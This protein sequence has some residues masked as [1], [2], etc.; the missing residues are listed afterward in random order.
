MKEISFDCLGLTI[1]LIADD[2]DLMPE[3]EQVAF[4]TTGRYENRGRLRFRVISLPRG[5]TVLFNDQIV[6][7][8]IDRQY[9]PY[10][11]SVFVHNHIASA[12]GDQGFIH[13]ACAVHRGRAF[14]IVGDKGA[15]KTTLSC[16]MLVQG[17]D[18]Q[19]DELV[20]PGREGVTPLPRKLLIKEG[21]PKL[22]T[23]LQGLLK[24]SISHHSPRY[25]WM[26]LVDPAVFNPVLTE[27]PLEVEAVF[28]LEADHK[29]PTSVAPLPGWQ[30]AARMTGQTFPAGAHRP[31]LLDRIAG[32]VRKCR[33]YSLTPGPPR[34][35]VEAITSALESRRSQRLGG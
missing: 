16:Q 9:L 17:M 32:L 12:L 18:V 22:V 35:A 15:G 25:G 28:C 20:I 8:V 31:A 21:T 1:S 23:E 29:G 14:L 19:A 34:Q 2:P 33:G 26:W 11:L 27:R 4:H 10:Y 30:L 7:T 24:D 6:F 13:C 3:L 5:C